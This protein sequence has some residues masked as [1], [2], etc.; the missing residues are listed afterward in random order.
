M[1][2]AIVAAIITS[3]VALLS[4][5][6]TLLFKKAYDRRGL[7]DIKGRRKAVIGTWKGI[8]SQEINVC[9]R[10]TTSCPCKQ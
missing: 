2:G 6:L 4:P 5:I 10:P 7:G 9:L 1:Q 8:I 3:S